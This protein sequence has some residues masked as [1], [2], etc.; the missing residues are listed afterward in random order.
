MFER[1]TPNAET[2][3]QTL[4]NN[5]KRLFK[6]LQDGIN[7]RNELLGQIANLKDTP[8]TTQQRIIDSKFVKIEIKK[9]EVYIYIYEYSLNCQ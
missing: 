2:D 6:E 5:I 7:A 8:K 3:E 4:E 9:A 1:D